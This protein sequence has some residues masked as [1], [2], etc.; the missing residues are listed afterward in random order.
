[1][2]AWAETSSWRDD[3]RTLF[4]SAAPMTDGSPPDEETL[5]PDDL[6]ALRA[7]GHRMLDDM[8]D[9]VAGIR[10][11]PVWQPMPETARRALRAPVPRDGEPADEVYAEF[12]TRIAP[13]P[14]GNDDPRF[15]A[16][17]MG[18]GTLLGM[19]PTCWPPG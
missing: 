17:V 2:A 7:L 9:R 18:N 13:Y 19:W 5:D 15:W 14:L 16:W 10:N 3:S 4:N 6:G 12:L 1:M 8:F 11:R